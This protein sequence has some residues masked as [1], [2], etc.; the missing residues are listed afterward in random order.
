MQETAE[1]RSR[2]LGVNTAPKDFCPRGYAH[3]GR[4]AFLDEPAGKV[5]VIALLDYW[6]QLALYPLHAWIFE[7]LKEVPTD[8]TFDQL[9][10]VKR[11]LKKVSSETIIYSY[12][13]KAATDR[14]PVKLQQSILQG[15]FGVH[16]AA[17]WKRLLVGRLY[18]LPPSV[19]K[20]MGLKRGSGISY[21]VGQP[22]GGYSSWA[23]LALTHHCMVQF[24]AYRAGIK[25]WF[26]LYAVLGDDIVI[27]HDAVAKQYVALCDL[28]GVEI[29]IAKSLVS[30]DKTLEFAKRFFRKG[31]DTS[32]MP[33]AFWVAA[34]STMGVAHALSAW[35]PA[36]TLSNFI[37]A[38]GTGFK[39]ASGANSSWVSMTQ[40]VRA[41]I[42]TLTHPLVG[43]RY[44]FTNWVEW[45]W[46]SGPG[47]RGL[48]LDSLVQFTPFATGLLESVLSPVEKIFDKYQEDLFFTEKVSDPSSRLVDT[49]TNRRMVEAE[50]S[51]NKAV[52]AMKHLQKLNIKFNLTQVSA[53]LTQV[54]RM[55]EKSA[56]VPAPAVKAMVKLNPEPK[57]VKVSDVYRYWNNLRGRSGITALKQPGSGKVG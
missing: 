4:L 27:A 56:L 11:L 33:I 36:G 22:M 34:Q 40:K 5:R 47:K 39:A 13:L 10:P 3:N 2:F 23:M 7:C 15:L 24:A 46:S 51:L 29:G 37:R 19:S 50:N 35:S 32:G 54:T 28:I 9:A 20:L 17:A 55:A 53:I 30:S 26:D 43:S 1:I 12:D 18:H 6:S 44:S 25:G 8:G 42:V 38:I 41:L 16:F 52:E 21:T 49:T 31:E 48:N 14:L 57:L 45:L